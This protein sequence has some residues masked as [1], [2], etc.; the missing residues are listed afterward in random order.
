MTK[1]SSVM[2]LTLPLGLA[3][4]C[5]EFLP[6]A[7]PT[8]LPLAAFTENYV[9]VNISFE[10]DVSGQAW[11]SAAFV[12]TEPQYYLYSKDLP[13]KGVNGMGRPTLL[14]L[15]PGSRLRAMGPLSESVPVEQGKGPAGLLHYPPGPVVLRLPVGV[16]EGKGWF[17]DQVSVTYMACNGRICRLPL[18]GKWIPIRVPGNKT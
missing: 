18:E 14:E 2:I 8:P 9:T 4:A 17:D 10:M 16:P 11:L 3:A 15:V 12:P 6:P 7:L 13:R 1:Y 5:A